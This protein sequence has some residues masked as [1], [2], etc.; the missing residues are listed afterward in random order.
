MARSH[1]QYRFRYGTAGRVYDLAVVAHP[2]QTESL[3]MGDVL[4]GLL[5]HSGR[6]VLMVPAAP[7][8]DIGRTIVIAWNGS[9]EG[10]RAVSAA[11]PFL[12]HAERI[13]IVTVGDDG[14]GPDGQALADSLKWHGLAAEV[15]AIRDETISDGAA[16]LKQCALLDANLLVTGAY[17]H[18]RLRALILGGV[19]QDIISRAPLPVLFTH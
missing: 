11:M 2:E 15:L 10:A 19:T 16:I 13:I 3:A 12:V 4:E 6:P 7:V 1:G 9:R 8:A 17:S 5:F 14:E 18:S